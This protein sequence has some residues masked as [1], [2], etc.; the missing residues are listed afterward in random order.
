MYGQHLH[1]GLKEK[2]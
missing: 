2:L 1:Q